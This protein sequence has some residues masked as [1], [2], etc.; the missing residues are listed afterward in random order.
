MNSTTPYLSVSSSYLGSCITSCN[1]TYYGDLVDGMCKLC[2]T[3]NINCNN[4]SSQTTCYSCNT[5]FMLYL[6]TCISTPPLGY[7]NNGGVATLCDSNCATCSNFAINCTS[8]VGNLNLDNNICILNCPAGKIGLNNLCQ[9]CNSTVYF[10]KTCWTTQ[11]YCTSCVLA[12]PAVFLSLGYCVT[13]CPN[14]TYPDAANRSCEPC[15]ASS[16]C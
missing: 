9:A 11:T 5:G 3:L 14:Y 4:C 10:C 7:Y 8:C 1:N 13:T 6:N 16:H 15:T 2:S 12:T